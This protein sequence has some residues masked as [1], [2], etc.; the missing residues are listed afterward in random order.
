MVLVWLLYGE[1]ATGSI[2]H[3]PWDL[4]GSRGLSWAPLHERRKYI[5]RPQADMYFFKTRKVVIGTLMSQDNFLVLSFF[6]CVHH[7]TSFG[8]KAPGAR[9]NLESFKG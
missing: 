6:H 2:E 4:L 8:S 1:T 9:S 3:G 5:L 7:S